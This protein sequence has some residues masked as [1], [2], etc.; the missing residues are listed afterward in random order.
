MSTTAE[1]TPT[2]PAASRSLR[3]MRDRGTLS[4]FALLPVLLVLVVVGAVTTDAFFTYDNLLTILQQSSELAIVTLALTIALIAGKFDLSL[5]STLGVA[6]LVAAWLVVPETVGGAG[7]GLDPYLA[8]VVAL[9]VGVAIGATNA[10]LI[11][12]LRLNAFVVTLAMLIL[13][14]G[15]H[16][17]ITNGGT[18]YDL[19]GPITFLGTADIGDV[20]LSVVIAAGLFLVFGLL[21]RYHRWGRSLYAI[22][23]NEDAARAAGINVER[24]L[25]G[26]LILASLLAALAGIMLT[27]RLGAVTPDQG[28]N[29]IFTV[30][31][32]AVIGGI[33]LNGGRGTLLGALTG[34]LLLGVISN[35]LV[36]SQVP[37]FWIDAVYGGIILL[38][39]VLTK[40]T[41]REDSG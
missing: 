15:C 18:L 1:A 12:R 17:G 33:S 9:V 7:L 5:E 3:T 22:G 27:G 24:M 29:Y 36:L 35:L 32:A 20:P 14:R 11:V 8:L 37:T 16:L 23:G 41:G 28:R 34:V 39:L 21:L 2:R 38:A 10:F 26:A 31:A 19:P 13:L 25:W 40:F 4:Q 30:F 6:P